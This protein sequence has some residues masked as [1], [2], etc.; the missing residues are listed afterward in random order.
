MIMEKRKKDVVIVSAKRTPI[1]KFLGSLGNVPP[2]RLAAEAIKSALRDAKLTADDV[3]ETFIGCVL[4]AGNGQNPARQAIL[5]AGASHERGAAVTVNKVCG[6]GLYSVVLAARA[7]RSGD[8]KIAIAGGMESMSSVP[9]YSRLRNGT[10]MGDAVF[11]DGIMK[12]GLLDFESSEAMG[13]FAEEISRKYSVTREDQ[14][15]FAVESYRKALHAINN[16]VFDQ[17][18][19]PV[20]LSMG[21]KSVVLMKDEIPVETTYESAREARPAFSKT[22]TVTAVNASKL[23]DG[24]AV[25]VVMDR[26]EAE[27]RGLEI[28]CQVEDWCLDNTTV[29]ELLVAPIKSIRNLLARNELTVEDIDLFEIN[30]AFSASSV[31]I[32]RELNIPD[33]KVNIHGG[34]VALG[35]PLG[36]SGS[37]ILVTLVS[38]MIQGNAKKGVASL[39]IGGGAAVSMLITR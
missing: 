24:A 21:R 25:V 37:R 6:S 31:A 7:I 29:P 36:A 28:L 30:E 10:K 1:G 14:D 9:H 15:L 22:G 23:A 26:E 39:C 38:A 12:D 19:A 11:E 16:G 4:P 35:H 27:A 34:S 17:E 3:D 13:V 20:E 5:E 8:V 2:Q 33:E 18:T 32:N